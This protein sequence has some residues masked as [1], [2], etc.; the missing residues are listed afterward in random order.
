LL[1]K[2]AETRNNFRSFISKTENTIESEVKPITKKSRFGHSRQKKFNRQEFRFDGKRSNLRVYLWGEVFPN[3]P[4]VPE[5][6][7]YY[8]SLLKTETYARWYGR[9]NLTN[10]LGRMTLNRSIQ[11][12]NKL[13]TAV[14][15]G[16]KGHEAIGYFYGDDERAD[17]VLRRALNISVRDDME[18]IGA[19]KCYVIDAQT[20]RGTYTVW[21]DPAHGYNI[22]KAEVLRKGGDVSGGVQ[23]SRTI[24][25]GDKEYTLLSN[26]RFKQIDGVWVPVEADIKYRWHLPKSFGYAY[27]EKIHHRVTEFIINPDHDAFGSFEWDDIQNGAKVEIVQVCGISYIWQDG[28]VVDENGRVIMDCRPKKASGSAESKPRSA[29]RKRP[30]AWELLRRYATQQAKVTDP[31]VEEQPTVTGGCGGAYAEYGGYG[32]SANSILSKMRQYRARL[33]NLQCLVEYDDFQS[34]EAQ[35]KTL[36]EARQGGAPAELIKL[37]ENDLSSPSKHNY[38]TQ[39]I[40][41]DNKGRAKIE[42]TGGTYDDSGNKVSAPEKSIDIWDGKTSIAYHERPGIAPP[43]AILGNTPPSTITILR[44]PLRSFGGKFMDAFSKAVDVGQ[45]IDV[46]KNE[47]DGTFQITFMEGDVKN[48]GIID[49][50]KGFS[51]VKSEQY[52]GD[53]LIVRFTGEFVEFNDGAW[54]PTKGKIESYFP[55]GQQNTISTVR[56]TRIKINDPAFNKSLFHLDFPEGTM[57]M[58]A[59]GRRVVELDS[60]KPPGPGLV[61]KTLPSLKHFNLE[62]NPK[63]S[64]S[65]MILICFWDM[66]QRPSRHCIRQLA[67]QAEQ[68]KQKGVNVVAAQISKVNESTLNEWLKEFY[69]PYPV[70]MV[71]EGVENTRLAWGIKS[72]PWLILSDRDHVVTSEGFG[73]GELNEKIKEADNAVP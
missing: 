56:V 51:V 61:G 24:K 3:S 55:D 28:Q 46:E 66:N 64:K 31:Q 73:I 14:S 37:L 22:A 63:Q 62:L 33:K 52:R 5:N 12:E 6:D 15:R 26:V 44:R 7:P 50:A 9:A 2:Y 11:P 29:V 54:Y 16:Y 48:V 67:E 1:D 20:K 43:G 65:K 32:G 71:N 42:L 57:V 45:E 34:Y 8:T 10:D 35:K 27:W 72:L 59:H 25:Q 38:Q 60:N 47:E 30:S 18:K 4:I 21:I 53:S 36:E 58:Y 68:L 39:K 17:V 49:P 69:I 23:D 40:I 19:S 41:L 70:G 13:K